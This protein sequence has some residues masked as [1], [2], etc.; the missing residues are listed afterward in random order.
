MSDD[1]MLA[2]LLEI[3]ENNRKNK[4]IDVTVS[5]DSIFNG[6]R[7]TTFILNRFPKGQAQSELNVHR[8]IS[9]NSASSRAI[10]K[11]KYIDNI[12]ADPY[13]PVWTTDMKG[14]VGK[15]ITD[16]NIIK[17]L[18]TLY[19]NKMMYDIEYVQ[20]NYEG[21]HKQDSN[22]Q[23]DSY[24]RIPIIV[25][26]SSDKWEYFF[27]LRTASDVK[28]EFRRIALEMQRL[29]TESIPVETDYH[30]PWIRKNEKEY[31]IEDKLILS[32]AR[33]AWLSY[34]NHENLESIDIAKKTVDKLWSSKHYSPFDHCAHA[35]IYGNLYD[36]WEE[37]RI[38]Q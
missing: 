27:N 21:I 8:S 14:M 3:T 26:T 34:S 12:I 17:K 31:S 23:L 5:A 28:P 11:Q 1:V 37:Y 10:N 6:K 32:T 15:L 7:I 4:I 16:T 13:I 18:N 9:K 2:R 30:I 19:Y 24:V 35:S 36:G 25:T 33:S 22:T 38:C 20:K 29:Y